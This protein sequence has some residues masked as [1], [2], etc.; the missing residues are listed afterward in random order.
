MDNQTIIWAT[1]VIAIIAVLGR[2]AI[3]YQKKG[4]IKWYKILLIV[5]AIIAFLLGYVNVDPQRIIDS[6]RGEASGA[7]A[8]YTN[9]AGRVAGPDIPCFSKVIS[10]NGG[11][12]C[13][14]VVDSLSRTDYFIIKST[15]LT[16][17]TERDVEISEDNRERINRKTTMFEVT[18]HPK[19]NAEKYLPLY[20]LSL[21]SGGKI[22]AAIDERDAQNPKSLPVARIAESS[23]RLFAVAQKIDSTIIADTYLM[24][25]NTDEFS[26]NQTNY[27]IY[28]AIAGLLFAIVSVVLLIVV[29][30]FTKG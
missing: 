5:V 9:V 14:P 29:K 23:D 18:K 7:E 13:V 1:V 30:R 19:D 8:A 11:R 20:K 26:R 10:E 6:W 28:R 25:Y 2:V 16:D 17:A 22:L 15:V 21:I 3:N 12:Y 4:T 27:L 24:C